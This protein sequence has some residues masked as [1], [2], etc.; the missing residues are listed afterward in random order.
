MCGGPAEQERV[1]EGQARPVIFLMPHRNGFLLRKR[2][3]AKRNGANELRSLA[4]AIG[5]GAAR[6]GQAGRDRV[7]VPAAA[8]GL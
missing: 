1:S 4:F 2:Q 5:S 8:G 7:A 6:T 3:L